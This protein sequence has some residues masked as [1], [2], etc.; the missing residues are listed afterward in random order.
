MEAVLRLYA[1]SEEDLPAGTIRL[2][3]DERPC[4]LLDEVM[5]PIAPEPG[6]VKKVDNEYKR[7]GTCT[8]FVAYDIDRGLRYTEVREQRTKNEPRRIMRILWI[9]SWLL[10]IPMQ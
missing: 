1:R 8:V 9:V 6:K 10:I 4:Q 3:M 5:T 2:C 7:Q